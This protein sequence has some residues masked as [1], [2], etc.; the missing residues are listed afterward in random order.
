MWP[1]ACL[2]QRRPTTTEGSPPRCETCFLTSSGMH[3]D[4][5]SYTIF[6]TIV[7]RFRIL[8]VG[9]V[10]M[11]CYVSV[12]SQRL[13]ADPASTIESLRQ[14]IARQR[15]LQIRYAG[16]SPAI[17]HLFIWLIKLIAPLGESWDQNTCPAQPTQMSTLGLFHTTIAIS[18][19]TNVLGLNPDAI[20]TI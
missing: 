8:V 1:G 15:Y 11:D 9:K 7:R 5:M 13:K 20:K 16:V 14:V 12:P 6:S 4:A 2:P 10:R 17:P 18:S 19:S 3:P